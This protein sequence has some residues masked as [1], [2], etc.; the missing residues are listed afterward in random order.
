MHIEHLTKAYEAKADEELLHLAGQASDLT[1]EAYIA[2]RSEMAR[3]RID[4][5]DLVPQTIEQGAIRQS[6]TGFRGREVIGVAEFVAEAIDVYH[7]QFW[8]FLRLVAPAVAIGWFA[9]VIGRN[10]SREIAGHI[11]RGI[12]GVRPVELVEMAIANLAGLFGSWT[13]FSFSFAAISVAVQK[14]STGFVPSI[15]ECFLPVRARLGPFLRLSS[16][17]FVF[18]LIAEGA[19][20]GFLEFGILWV[21]ERLP[22]HVTGLMISLVSFVCFGLGLLVM[23]RFSLAIPALILDKYRVGDSIFR[24]DEYTE[25]KWLKL[26]ALIAKSVIGGYVAAMLPFWIAAYILRNVLVP[27]WFSWVLTAASIAA[28]SVVEPTMFIGFTLLYLRRSTVPPTSSHNL[29]V[30]HQLSGLHTPMENF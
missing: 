25:R 15:G 12:G 23:S 6:R 27:W 30:S 24:S 3:R 4:V 1:P 14:L 7:H 20:L 13:A 17:L 2:L 19:A 10:E 26:A 28:A 21:L 18:L 8:L 11:P 5:P 9:V 22:I 29:V 16:L